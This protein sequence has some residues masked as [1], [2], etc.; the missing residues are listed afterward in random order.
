MFCYLVAFEFYVLVTTFN[1]SNI[2]SVSDTSILWH[3]PINLKNIQNAINLC[4][5][6]AYISYPIPFVFHFAPLL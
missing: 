1:S 3:I 5:V 2:N 4:L 6:P